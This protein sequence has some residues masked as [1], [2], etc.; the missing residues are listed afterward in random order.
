[1]QCRAK[2]LHHHSHSVGALGSGGFSSAAN[3]SGGGLSPV[4]PFF[5]PLLFL[6]VM[7]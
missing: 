3:G 1:M 2:L 6:L 5:P 7:A 4:L